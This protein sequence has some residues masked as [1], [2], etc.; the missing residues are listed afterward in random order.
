V[1]GLRSMYG[2]TRYEG[3]TILLPVTSFLAVHRMMR[4][5]PVREATILLCNKVVSHS[6]TFQGKKSFHHVSER[7][8]NKQHHRDINRILVTA[9]T[10]VSDRC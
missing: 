4:K 9:R 8:N 10:V 5:I 1:Y 6:K 2:R 3:W 7:K